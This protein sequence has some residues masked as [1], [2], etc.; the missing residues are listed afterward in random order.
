MIYK[1]PNAKPVR[2]S[3]KQPL[4]G[5][6]A[7]RLTLVFRSHAWP[8]PVGLIVFKGLVGKRITIISGRKALAFIIVS[9]EYKM[10][11]E[12]LTLLR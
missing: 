9:D 8:M 1:G 6:L 12:I 3:F 11:S 7:F 2:V 10:R 4:I 5:P